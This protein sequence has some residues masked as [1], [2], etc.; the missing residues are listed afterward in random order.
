MYNILTK[1]KRFLFLIA[2][3]AVVVIACYF[4]YK[5]LTKNQLLSF[6]L[7]KAQL[8]V[9]FNNNSWSLFIVL[10][11]T[12]L[13]WLL[14]FFKWKGLASSVYKTSFFGAIEQT[15]ASLTASIVTPNRIGEYGVKALYFKKGYR[16]KI[17]LLNLIGNLAQLAVTTIFGTIG[18][19]VINKNYA[20][21]YL[22]FNPLKLI[23]ILG[24]CLVLYLLI[25]KTS[26]HSLMLSYFTKTKLFLKEISKSTLVETFLYSLFRYLIF[27]YQFFYIIHLFD[28]SITYITIIPYIF[29]FY[30]MVSII[31]SLAIFDWAVKGSIALFIFDTST[32]NELAILSVTTIIWLLNFAIPIVLGSFFILRFKIAKNT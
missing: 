4:I 25:R 11:L 26:Y 29:S 1:Y 3:M 32:L 17:I 16:K 14:E 12:T 2:K 6:E 8:A 28:P 10:L 31:P 23:V 9:V 27:S 13:N 7:F 20:A 19:I 24:S 18:M 30:I 5:Q 22:H 15:L 21:Q